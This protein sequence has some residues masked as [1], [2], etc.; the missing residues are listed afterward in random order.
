MNKIEEMIKIEFEFFQNVNNVGGRAACQDD[1]DTFWIMRSSQFHAWNEALLNSYDQD[2]KKA[3]EQHRNL[4][5]EKY[6][7]MSKSS[8]P[9][10]WQMLKDYLPILDQETLNLIEAIVQIQVTWRKE[11]DK[12]YPKLSSNARMVHT[13]E[14][15]IDDISF[16]TYLRAELQTYG[17]KTIEY[18]GQYVVS[19]LKENKNLTEMIMEQTV[20][21]YGYASLKDAEDKIEKEEK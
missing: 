17:Q 10:R 12:K 21:L 19:L 18:Y 1:Y 11:F 14:D 4:M 13:S 6:A 3:K 20:K 8:E 15:Q 9:K 5:M 2:L 16:E 7:R